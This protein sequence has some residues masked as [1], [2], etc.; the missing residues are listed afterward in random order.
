[1]AE[2]AHV[3]ITGRRLAALKAATQA[4]GPNATSVQGNASDLADLDRLY[5]T[6]RAGGRRVPAFRNIR[7]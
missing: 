7:P 4:I 5:A 2:G 6:V 1:V 3:Y